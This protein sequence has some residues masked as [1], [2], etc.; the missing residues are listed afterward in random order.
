MKL[1]IMSDLHIELMCGKT[2][3]PTHADA[4]VVILAGDIHQGTAGLHWARVQFPS[5]EIVYVAGNHEYYDKV[6]AETLPA[7]RK[8]A[9]KLGI[10]F[11]NR[12]TIELSGVRILGVTL[13]TDFDLYGEEHR[14]RCLR[15]ARICMNDYRYIKLQRMRQK[16]MGPKQWTALTPEQTR[17]WCMTDKEWL[18]EQLA[19]PFAGKTVV[20]THHLPSLLS[21]SA[22]YSG[23]LLN[24]A[25][26][27]DLTALFGVPSLWVH[28]HTHDSCDY[29]F[30]SGTRV[31]CNPRGYSRRDGSHENQVF[32]EDFTVTL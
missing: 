8:V 24:A 15:E 18:A 10:H 20:V 22:K 12:D 9:A 19:I 26:A 27:S 1:Q 6:W 31:V 7:L 32:A 17:T 14:A 2:F 25:F 30:G 21:V 4:D 11:L 28:G 5:Q 16:D 3:T 29:A 13:W 23:D